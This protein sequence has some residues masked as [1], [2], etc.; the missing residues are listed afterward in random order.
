MS[1]RHID[2]K[3]TQKVI[4]GGG[5]T[6]NLCFQC[7]TCT[8]SCPS[9]R[10]TAFR[11]RKLIRQAQLGFPEVL[12]SDEL[13]L[14]TTCY[15]CQ[16]RCP[17]GVEIVDVIMSLRNMAVKKGNMAEAH[18][19]AAGYLARFGAL[20]PLGK[21]PEPRAWRKNVGLPETSPVAQ[22]NKEALAQV[23]K[24]IEITG[25][26]KLIAKKEGKEETEKKEEGKPAE[27]KKEA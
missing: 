24:I 25:F 9:G 16:E 4:K 2:P 21:A 22:F 10:Q 20:V 12:D 15:T 26:D 5:K 27:E 3:F 19:K 6:V 1:P 23:H 13:W 8:G 14:C 11:T 18:R 7:G 17:R